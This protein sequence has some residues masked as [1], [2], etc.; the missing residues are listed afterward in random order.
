MIAENDEV[1]S[2]GQTSTA[3]SKHIDSPAPTGVGATAAMC[4]DSPALLEAARRGL[5][6]LGVIDRTRVIF[7]SLMTLPAPIRGELLLEIGRAHR[8]A[9]KYDDRSSLSA[10]VVR[11]RQENLGVET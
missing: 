6:R 10:G 8:S 9:P 7:G 2:S 1:L 5:E 11:R 4:I 3:T